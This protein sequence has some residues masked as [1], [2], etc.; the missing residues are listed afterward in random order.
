[1]RR[2]FLLAALLA[3]CTHASSTEIRSG[4]Y[5]VECNGQSA[6]DCY[7]EARDVCPRGYD[8]TDSSGGN[9]VRSN[10]FNGAP[11]FIHH[12]ELTVRC[13]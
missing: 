3:G 11:V 8:V 13:R 9:E 4:V 5:H 10:L 2:T 7:E 6:N 12:G 1:M